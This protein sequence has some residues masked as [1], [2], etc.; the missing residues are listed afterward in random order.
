MKETE[1]KSKIYIVVRTS[2]IAF[3][4]WREAPPEFD[5]LRNWHRHNFYVEMKVE[6]SDNREIEFNALKDELNEFLRGYENK[7]LDMS[8]EDI[9]LELAKRFYPSRK[10]IISIFE[11]NENGVEIET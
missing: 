11:D 2:F 8:C 4:R 10:K 7:Y 3:H 1:T 9:A 5:Y 6:E